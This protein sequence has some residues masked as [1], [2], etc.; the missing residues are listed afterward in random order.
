MVQTRTSMEM[1]LRGEP[2]DSAALKADLLAA[3]DRLV[4]D[5]SMQRDSVYR[6]HRRL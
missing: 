1:I 4:F 2:S 5:F 3:A 6:R